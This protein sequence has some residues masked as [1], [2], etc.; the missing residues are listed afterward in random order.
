MKNLPYFQTLL[1]N[2]KP[3][4]YLRYPIKY[5]AIFGSYSRGD[6]TENSD[7]DV[8]VDFKQPIGIRFIDLADELEEKLNIKVDLVSRKAIKPKYFKQIKKDLLYV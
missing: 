7:L 4:L 8:L 6:N 2:L 5:I 3:D 1:L